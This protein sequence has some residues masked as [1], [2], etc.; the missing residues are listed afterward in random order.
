MDYYG[1]ENWTKTGE[2]ILSEEIQRK[3]QHYLG[4]VGFLIVLH[5]HFCGAKGP[6]RL[7]FD[8]YDEFREY[9]AT[10]A[11]PGDMILIWPFPEGDPAFEGKY[12]NEKGEI[13]IKGAY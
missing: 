12:P 3:I 2:N 11:R 6:T 7:V 8:D 10:N 5:R 9:L 4:E 1:A 13:P